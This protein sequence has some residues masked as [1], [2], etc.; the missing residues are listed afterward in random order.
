MRAIPISG[1][2]GNWLKIV[3]TAQRG[4]VDSPAVRAAGLAL[5]QRLGRAPGVVTSSSYWSLGNVPQL[6]S[7]NSRQALVVASLRGT[8][9][10]KLKV[11][12]MLSK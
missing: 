7:R 12:A 9:D 1:E 8:D 3:V 6:R 2:S 10:A 4:T 11:A 5:T